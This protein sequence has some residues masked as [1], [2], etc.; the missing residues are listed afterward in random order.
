M[1]LRQLR[2]F[3]A[4]FNQKSISRAAEQL[5]I[6]QPALTRQ[7]RLLEH[8]CGT[9]LFERLPKGTFPTPAGV[10]LHK[11]ALTMLAMAGSARDV[12]R[13]AGPVR[14]PVALGLA[15]GLPAEWVDRLL[16]SVAD[17][18]PLAELE[19]TDGDTT[20]QLRMVREGRLDIGLVHQEPSQ[21]LVGGHVRKEFFGLALRPGLAADGEAHCHLADFHDQR[22]LIHSR[23]QFPLGHDRLLA[24]SHELGIAPSWQIATFNEHARACADATS[25]VAVML[26]EAS[27]SR[28]LPDWQW[29]PLKEPEMALETWLVRQPVTRAIVEKVADIILR[30]FL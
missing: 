17:Q 24:T 23:E 5:L 30:T 4:V 8:E 3:V 21:D 14:Q 16:A 26:T 25:S 19:L 22:V 2:Y 18:A 6:S 27:A 28:L 13:Q 15:P 1:E 12:A 11:H 7:I 29:K 9:P 20:V 10:A